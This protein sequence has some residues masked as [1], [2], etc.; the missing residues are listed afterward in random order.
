M[1]CKL[2]MQPD[3]GGV[4]TADAPLFGRMA[5]RRVETLNRIMHQSGKVYSDDSITELNRCNAALTLATALG[6]E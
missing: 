1:C 6:W 3:D 5:I 4:T 2:C